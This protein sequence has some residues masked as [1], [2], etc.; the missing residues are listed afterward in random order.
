MLFVINEPMGHT[1]IFDD[2]SICLV[3]SCECREVQ[4]VFL[5]FF[6]H[7][8]IPFLCALATHFRRSRCPSTMRCQRNEHM[9]SDVLGIIFL[10]VIAIRVLFRYFCIRASLNF[11]RYRFYLLVSSR[12]PNHC[13]L[14]LCETVE[15]R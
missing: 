11:D 5:M 13:N 3:L 9:F 2:C 15:K 12:Y 1:C 14:R 7:V 4:A 10:C 6:S 8:M